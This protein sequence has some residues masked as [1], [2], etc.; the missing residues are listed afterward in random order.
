MIVVGYIELT[1][2]LKHWNAHRKYHT[3]PSLHLQAR[4]LLWWLKSQ[5][6]LD[7]WV[8]LN[9]T[10]C[11]MLAECRSVTRPFHSSDVSIHK[12]V[13]QW[14]SHSSLKPLGKNTSKHTHTNAFINVITSCRSK[15]VCCYCKV[16]QLDNFVLC[17]TPFQSFGTGEYYLWI[18]TYSSDYRLLVWSFLTN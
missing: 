3:H 2:L 9:K 11:F 6:C 10:T 8:S 13:L 1:V 14:A 5:R 4:G 7:L 12:D 18:M 15:P 16:C 17:M